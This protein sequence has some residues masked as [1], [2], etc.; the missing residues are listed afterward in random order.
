MKFKNSVSLKLHQDIRIF[1]IAVRI[2]RP[3][4]L[5]IINTKYKL[6]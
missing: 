5:C 1:C 2:L 4:V 3:D 6:A